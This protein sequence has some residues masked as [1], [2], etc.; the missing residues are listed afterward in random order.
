MILQQSVSETFQLRTAFLIHLLTFRKCNFVV[1]M[2]MTEPYNS[3]V[4]A[5]LLVCLQ[6]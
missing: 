2:C 6:A 5:P 3:P 1:Y 4:A